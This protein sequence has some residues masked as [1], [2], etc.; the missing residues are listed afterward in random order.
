[1]QFVQQYFKL[2]VLLVGVSI[3]AT[4]TYA[5]YRPDLELEPSSSISELGELIGNPTA[6]TLPSP[7]PVLTFDEPMIA[8]RLTSLVLE[9]IVDQSRIEAAQTSFGNQLFPTDVTQV[10]VYRF[11]YDIQGR[12]GNWQP[13][14]ARVYVPVT[15]TSSPLYVFGSGTTGMADKCAPSLENMAVENLG[16]YENQMISQAAA[17]YVT[18]FPDYEGFNDAEATQAYFIVESE[19][20]VLLGAIQQLYEA[21]AEIRA[22]INFEQVFLGGYSQGGHAALSAAQYWSVLP[23]HIKLKGIIQFAGAADV[24]ALFVDSPHLA[25]YLSESFASYYAPYVSATDVLQTDWLVKMAQDNQNLC[26][27]AAYRYYPQDPSLVYALP[28]LD[29][30]ITRVWP[31]SLINW[32]QVI[33]YNTP[34][35]NLPNVPYLSIQGSVDPIVT[36]ETQLKNIQLLCHQDKTVTYRTYEGINHFQIRQQSFSLANNWMKQVLANQPIENDCDDLVQQIVPTQ[37]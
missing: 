7:S 8:S 5:Y 27:N 13:V 23:S 28:F 26:V 31:T 12:D 21:R 36:P 24:A 35:N 20:K 32:Q 4:E 16:N 18:V 22:S 19:A 2:A 37:L 25:A 15:E 10:G 14:V 9:K 11:E 17:G 33:D 29:A 30:V 34:R 1:M 3:L 6:P